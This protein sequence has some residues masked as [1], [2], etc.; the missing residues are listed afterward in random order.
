MPGR[1]HSDG[2]GQGSHGEGEGRGPHGG[3]VD[4]VER[5][6]VV[7]DDQ[8]NHD[9]KAGDGSCGGGQPHAVPGKAAEGGVGGSD[10]GGRGGGLVW[11]R[12]AACHARRRDV[13]G[14]GGAR[15][16]RGGD[17]WCD[18]GVDGR[19]GWPAAGC[20]RKEGVCCHVLL[21]LQGWVLRARRRWIY[22]NAWTIS[23]NEGVSQKVFALGVSQVSH[24][25]ARE[26]WPS[27]TAR[28]CKDS[29]TT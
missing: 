12:R 6:E 22:R 2:H 26:L 27:R 29:A 19:G 25:Q 7:D 21:H 17:G 8:E 5:G 16:G 3:A 20:R 28:P 9:S 11:V 4:A 15:D 13:V 14:G 23:R 1:C 24:E 10:G 18:G